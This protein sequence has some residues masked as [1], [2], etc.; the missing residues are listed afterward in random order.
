M[1]EQEDTLE[2]LKQARE[3]VEGNSTLEYLLVH[4]R[5]SGPEIQSLEFR[6]PVQND[7]EDLTTSALTSLIDDVRDQR[8]TVRDLTALNTITDESVL[9]NAPVD[10]LPDTEL[11]NALTDSLR[12]YP[13]GKYDKDDP[14]D[15]QLI[16][17]SDGRKALI[18]VQNHRGLKT[19]DETNEGLPLFYD[20]SVYEKFGGSILIVPEKLNAVYFDGEVFVKSPKSFE[21]MFEMRDEYEKQAEEVIN[22]FQE[23]GIGF[24]E[25]KLTDEWLMGDIRVL[26]RLYEIYENGIPE[27]ATPKKIR[28]L[29]E[30]Y[31]VSVEYE[32][33][34]DELLLDVEE[35]HDIWALLRVMNADYAEAEI[36]PDARIEIGSKRF[37][38]N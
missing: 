6:K 28:Q 16:R 1:T 10:R 23:A 19:Y 25:E 11:F 32:T 7:F 30:K 3:F 5:R 36:I 4:K 17:I 9:Q 35:Y 38:D 21:K 26:R 27:Y 8:V 15:F 12:D 2:S 34:G 24:A 14:P 33:S 20:N 31:D 29:I 37:I 13:S 18:G 22:S